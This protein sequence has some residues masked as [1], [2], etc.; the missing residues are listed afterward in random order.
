MVDGILAI[1]KPAGL[2]SR[3][4]STAV[5]KI[6]NC[7]AGHCGTLDPLATGVL[8]VCV[9]KARLLSRF[10][11]AL[12]KSYR[13]TVLFGVVTDTYDVTGNVIAETDIDWLTPDLIEEALQRF[14]GEIIQ[15]PPAFSAI[16]SKGKPLYAYARRGE[17]VIPASR[18]IKIH[19]IRLVDFRRE[20]SK[21]IA[22]LEVYCGEGAYM[23][24]LAN[25]LGQVIGCGACV[26]A[27][28]RLSIGRF[29]EKSL[30]SYEAVR[31][32]D[33]AKIESKLIAMEEATYFLP[34]VVVNLDGEVSVKLGKPLDYS[35]IVA[36]KGKTKISGS[37]KV[38]NSE[39]KIIAIYGPP[40]K[41]D[42]GN[43]IGRA[44]RVLN[45]IEEVKTDND[46]AIKDGGVSGIQ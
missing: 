26:L 38:L 2:T 41:E 14:T 25:D 6:F 15:V 5:G 16:K 45:S 3:Q 44:I 42:P 22:E 10:L 9:G 23:R 43:I 33:R 35:M 28:R 4:V 27:L 18:K 32:G 19:S 8:L 11:S 17:M 36:P 40:R 7:K 13:V 46:S 20:D 1:D 39:G 37:T 24:S 31:S 34:S 21:T 30:I 29:G 12:D